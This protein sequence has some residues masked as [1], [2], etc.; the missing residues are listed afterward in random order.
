M[1]SKDKSVRLVSTQ[2]DQF[3]VLFDHAAA[4][5]AEQVARQL[6]DTGYFTDQTDNWVALNLLGAAARPALE[7]ACP[8]DLHPDAFGLNASARTVLDHLGTL[9]VHTGEDRYL[10]LSARS[11]ALSFLHVLETVVENVI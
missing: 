9:V 7:R 10:L 6:G 2:A 1:L 4:D 3:F 8:L 5:A 11:S